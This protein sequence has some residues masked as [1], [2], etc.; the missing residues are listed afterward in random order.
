MC[1]ADVPR[2]HTVAAV[3]ATDGEQAPS[4]AK[5]HTKSVSVDTPPTRTVNVPRSVH[6]MDRCKL[7]ILQRLGGMLDSHAANYAL[8][9]DEAAAYMRGN[10]EITESGGA[11]RRRTLCNVDFVKAVTA[12]T[13]DV[14]QCLNG[15]G[16]TA[17]VWDVAVWMAMK[18]LLVNAS[19]GQRQLTTDAFY[20]LCA[21]CAVA[22]VKADALPGQE[23]FCGFKDLFE[24]MR[25]CELLEAGHW[26]D[27]LVAEAE[28]C[29]SVGWHVHPITAVQV[30]EHIV[31]LMGASDA[32][33]ECASTKLRSIAVRSS[34]PLFVLSPAV[35]AAAALQ[36]AYFET[37]NW[38]GHSRMLAWLV[39]ETP[40]VLRNARV[41]LVSAF[42]EPAWCGYE[43]FRPD[44]KRACRREQELHKGEIKKVVASV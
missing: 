31:P 20:M 17:R 16:P 37:E 29:E 14:L 6:T 40:A 39:R 28:L 38:H 42:D 2:T 25:N 32:V 24:W 27:L 23:A 33:S 43:L 7:H 30:L 26:R 12:H 13:E 10:T 18:S 19:K 8:G 41:C 44:A 3:A 1:D 15:R 34:A 9:E 5:Q 4:V 35:V 36:L 11:R 22:A 21:T